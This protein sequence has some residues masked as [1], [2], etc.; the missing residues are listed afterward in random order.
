[1]LTWTGCASNWVLAD[2][3]VK[4]RLAPLVMAD[5]GQSVTAQLVA[6]ACAAQFAIAVAPRPEIEAALPVASSFLDILHKQ[7][8]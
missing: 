1:L 8:E 6:E 4:T 5:A 7:F 3:F 2:R